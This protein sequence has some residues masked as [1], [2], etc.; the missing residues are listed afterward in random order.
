MRAIAVEREAERAALRSSADLGPTVRHHEVVDADGVILVRDRPGAIVE[1]ERPDP[2]NP[3]RTVIGAR[4]APPQFRLLRERKLTPWQYEAAERFV[5][6]WRLREH[7][8]SPDPDAPRAHRAPWERNGEMSADR[9]AASRLL[10][11]ARVVLGPMAEAAVLTVCVAEMPLHK[12]WSHIM[13]QGGD[14]TG[15]VQQIRAAMVQGM[16]VVALDVLARSW[17]LGPRRATRVRL[18]RAKPAA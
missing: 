8:R 18:P 10:D 3:S 7:G 2:G 6:A 9:A 12:A 5:E 1:V 11:Q 13:G 17:K 15:P 4:T 16:L 14:G